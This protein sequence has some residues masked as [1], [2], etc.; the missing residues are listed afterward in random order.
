MFNGCRIVRRLQFELGA[1]MPGTDED[2]QNPPVMKE[3]LD[4]VTNEIEAVVTR[5]GKELWRLTFPDYYEEGKENTPARI[6]EIVCHGT[7]RQ[8]RNCFLNRK[9]QFDRYDEVFPLAAAQESTD[10]CLSIILSR[11]RSG[12]PAEKVW[13]DR[14]IE[15]LRTESE[16]LIRR[17]LDDREFDP[18]TE[19][20]MLDGKD[21]FT[22]NIIDMFIGCASSGKRSDAVSCLMD[23]KH[24]RFQTGGRSKYIL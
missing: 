17:I 3:I 11:L 12:P 19:L 7:G 21:Y 18:V 20:E 4:A 10:T 24:R 15:Y 9:L 23:I 5:T 8:Y 14:Y 16:S 2:W 22:S 1:G 6:I 13:T